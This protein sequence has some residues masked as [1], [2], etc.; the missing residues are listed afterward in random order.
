MG[1]VGWRLP[2]APCQSQSTNPWDGLK[3][4][5]SRGKLQVGTM[6]SWG[7][8]PLA[9]TLCRPRIPGCCSGVA[10]LCLVEGAVGVG[11]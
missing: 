4:R 8:C 7:W 3:G 5:G 11:M 6:S 1:A 2:A 9:G 10:S